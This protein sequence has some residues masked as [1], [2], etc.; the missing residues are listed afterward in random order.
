MKQRCY[1]WGFYL[2]GNILLAIGL[3]FFGAA[4]VMLIIGLS[5][6]YQ[7]PVQDRL[8]QYF[9]A[10]TAQANEFLNYLIGLPKAGGLRIGAGYL[11]LRHGSKHYILDGNDI[12]WAYQQTT[13]QKY[14]GIIP[15][16][17]THAVV[18]RLSDG[19]MYSV[20][21]ADKKAKEQLQILLNQFPT[22]A[23]GYSNQLLQIYNT[24]RQELRSIAAAQRSRSSL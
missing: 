11:L 17:K 19:K 9:G 15:M 14:M 12:I 23:I 2:L 18:L 4:L 10:N 24:N 13:T 16:G 20:P 5:G 21:M 1:R 7:K 3:A 8:R 22:V 6:H